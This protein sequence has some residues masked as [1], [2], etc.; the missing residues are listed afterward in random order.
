MKFKDEKNVHVDSTLGDWHFCHTAGV[1]GITVY[2]A[3]SGGN[4]AWCMGALI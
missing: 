1:L 3:T 4:P 2:F